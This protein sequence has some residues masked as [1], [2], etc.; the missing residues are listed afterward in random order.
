ML[1]TYITVNA[2]SNKLDYT[3]RG[4]HSAKQEEF[5]AVIPSQLSEYVKELPPITSR[6]ANAL[7]GAALC[8]RRLS[9]KCG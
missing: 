3:P 5:L 9:M 2:L 4:I 7:K 6:I 1:Y 8:H